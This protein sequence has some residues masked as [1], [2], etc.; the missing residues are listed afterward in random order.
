MNSLKKPVIIL[1]IDQI[2]FSTKLFKERLADRGALDESEYIELL[3]LT[4]KK[5]FQELVI[6]RNIPV[7]IF[8]SRKELIIKSHSYDTA[9][10][11]R[12]KD[13]LEDYKD[14]QIY[15]V[16]DQ[17]KLLKEAKKMNKDIVTILF[18]TK[19]VNGKNAKDNIGVDKVINKLKEILPIIVCN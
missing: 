12:L 2:L 5:V 8:S 18:Q 7:N 4:E 14:Y 15:L 10:I 6:K 19:I 11:K 1:D 3:Y 16:D 9:A 17:P 13:Y